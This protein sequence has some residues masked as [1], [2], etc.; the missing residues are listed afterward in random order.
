MRDNHYISG[1]HAH[2]QMNRHQDTMNGHTDI[3]KPYDMNYTNT[4][5]N[6]R[7]FQ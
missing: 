7:H 5:N 3:G 1:Y 2:H 4:E 6:D